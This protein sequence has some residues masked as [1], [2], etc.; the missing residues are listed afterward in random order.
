MIHDQVR[1][2][3]LRVWAQQACQV[4]ED[5]ERVLKALLAPGTE[6]KGSY[7]PRVEAAVTELTAAFGAADA[8]ADPESVVWRAF[9]PLDAEHRHQLVGEL[10]A[11]REPAA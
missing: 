5:R 3:L 6:K 9:S 7:R 11:L 4:P 10:L 8:P 1:D 2:A